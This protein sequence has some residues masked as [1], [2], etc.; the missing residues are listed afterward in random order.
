MEKYSLQESNMKQ[1]NLGIVDLFFHGGIIFI[2]ILLFLL[3]IELT[4]TSVLPYLIG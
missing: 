2:R 3:F 4:Q 1:K